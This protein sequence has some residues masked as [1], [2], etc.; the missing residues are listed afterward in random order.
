MDEVKIKKALALYESHL[1]SM[2]KYAKKKR[3]E[4]KQDGEVKCRGR[5]R[6][7]DE[8]REQRRRESRRAYYHRKKEE[9]VAGEGGTSKTD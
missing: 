9:A 3:E 6:L 2:R 4:K 1:E 7:T 5:P 8:E